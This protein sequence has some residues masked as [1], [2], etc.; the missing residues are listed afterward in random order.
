MHVLTAQRLIDHNVWCIMQSTRFS[1]DSL[2][3]DFAVKPFLRWAGSKRQLLPT[4]STYW[5]TSYGRYL[6]PFM[7]SASLFF[8]L[9]PSQAILSDVNRELVSTFEIVKQQHPEL[10]RVL[11]SMERGESSYYSLRDADPLSLDPVPRAARFIYLNRFCFNGLYRTNASGKFNV[12]FGGEKT[13]TLPD[14]A[15]LS[16]ASAL[17]SQST[18]ECADFEVVIRS[19]VRSNDFVYLDPP[20][21]VSNRRI[22]SQ[23]G[24][25]TFGLSD[26]LRLQHLLREIHARGAYFL[27]SY[28][29]SEEIGEIAREWQD[30]TVA[31]MR[32]IAGFARHRRNDSEILITN[33]ENAHQ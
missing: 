19:H 23:Y 6:E 22:F 21:A 15:S 2:E 25:S 10:L 13:G 3:D 1:L 17:L 28:S 5:S 31:V 7:G 18:L 8:S 9:K 26:I 33:I 29:A 11:G 4:L 20:F 14:A 27:L 24:P 32:N 12:P 30:Q 16:T